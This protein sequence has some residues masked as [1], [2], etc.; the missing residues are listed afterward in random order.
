MQHPHLIIIAGCNGAGK[1]T[2]SPYLVKEITPFDYDKKFAIIYNQ[3]RD[4]EFREQIAIHLVTEE[5]NQLISNSLLEKKTI[6]FETNLHVFPFTWINEAKQLGYKISMYF[7]CLK[8]IEL[9]KKRVEIRTKN[10][11]HFVNDETIAYKWKEGYK[12]LNNYFSL[13][14]K[15]LIIDNSTLY[16]PK[17]LFE[18]EKVNDLNFKYFRYQPTIPKYIQNRL[19]A[20]FDILQIP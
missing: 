15:I 10:N 6:C 5:L 1:S 2:F 12:N 7:F 8:N 14:D 9:A 4:S 16:K 20:I 19:P 18:L 3:L 13:F 17:I 11:G